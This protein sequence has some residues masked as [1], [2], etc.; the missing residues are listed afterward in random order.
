[1]CRWDL[2]SLPFTS[3]IAWATMPDQIVYEEAGRERDLP[4]HS[5]RQR[6]SPHFKRNHPYVGPM[7]KLRHFLLVFLYQ[8]LFLTWIHL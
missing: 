8:N 4:A 7:L 1:M 5:R 3:Y 2:A 6:C